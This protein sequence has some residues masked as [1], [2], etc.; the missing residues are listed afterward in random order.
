MDTDIYMYMYRH[1]HSFIY[2]YVCIHTHTFLLAKL[3]R[4]KRDTYCYDFVVVSHRINFGDNSYHCSD[5]HNKEYLNICH[6]KS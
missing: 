2:M 5:K 6:N 4:V 3:G 1:I